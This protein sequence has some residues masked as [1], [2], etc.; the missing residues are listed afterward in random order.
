MTDIYKTPDASLNNEQSP[1]EY[2]SLEKGITGDYTFSVG[3][4]L[5]EAWNRTDGAKWTFNMASFLYFIVAF[6][7]MF[8]T[9]LVTIP[10]LM[11]VDPNTGPGPMFFAVTFGQQIV[12]NLL[13]MPIAMGLFMLGLKRSVNA[14]LSATSIFGYYGKMFSLLGTLI[15]VYLMIVI[16]YILLIIPGI[17]LSIAYM[18]ALPLVVE[19]GLSPWAAMEASRKAITKRWFAFLGFFLLMMII[20]FISAIPLGIGLIWTGPMMI[21][22]F[23]II[24][25]NVFGCEASSIN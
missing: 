20:V 14:P 13:L 10:L 11:N 7:I 25:R 19:K 21:I 4:T 1:G 8:V 18:M 3:D 17:Y 5:S 9:N 24:Y 15:L 23:G 16:G 6:A 22:A 2:G 12:M